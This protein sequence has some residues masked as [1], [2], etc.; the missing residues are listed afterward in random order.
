MKRVWCRRAAGLHLQQ[1]P[2]VSLPALRP[3]P[4]RRGGLLATSARQGCRS[5]GSRGGGWT[6]GS[7]AAL[8]PLS[9]Q[10]QA[11]RDLAPQSH[12]PRALFP[13]LSSGLTSS[14]CRDR[15]GSSER[16]GGSYSGSCRKRGEVPSCNLAFGPFS[17]QTQGLLPNLRDLLRE[18]SRKP[19]CSPSR[20][21]TARPPPA[22]ARSSPAACAP[23]PR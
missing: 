21:P 15:V 7:P 23:R 11:S 20:W 3:L 10:P 2:L 16:P 19:R 17:P 18:T 4:T 6:G 14:P 9:R 13:H 1:R 12:S 22:T 8:G 5:L